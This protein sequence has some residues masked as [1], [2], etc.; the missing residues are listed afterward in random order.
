[1]PEKLLSQIDVTYHIPSSKESILSWT[2]NVLEGTTESYNKNLGDHFVDHIAAWDRSKIIGRVNISRFRDQSNNEMI[3]LLENL[4]RGKEILNRLTEINLNYVLGLIEEKRWISIRTR[5][6]VI[7]NV[8]ESFLG[9]FVG[10]RSQEKIRVSFIKTRTTM[11]NLIKWR[12]KRWSAK[13]VLIKVDKF[14]TN[15]INRDSNSSI[16]TL[17]DRDETFHVLVT[18]QSMKETWTSVTVLEEITL[19]LLSKNNF[20]A[21]LRLKR[22]NF[23]WLALFRREMS[24]LE[25]SRRYWWYSKSASILATL[26][27][28]WLNEACLKSSKDSSKT[29]VSCTKQTYKYQPLGIAILQILSLYN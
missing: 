7:S 17:D 25:S 29:W 13:E 15:F 3:N 14:S 5:S 18:H 2:N 22:F 19:E 10:H 16:T 11:N 1:M 28:L 27:E 9:T 20:S 21:Y 24:S 8:E 12:G 26:Y 4:F 23:N 6:F